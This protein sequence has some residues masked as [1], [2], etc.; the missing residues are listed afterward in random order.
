MAASPVNK[1][2]LIIPA[3]DNSLCDVLLAM[4]QAIAVFKA[5]LDYRVDPD[6]A[7]TENQPTRDFAN[8]LGALILPPGTVMPFSLSTGS[9]S[10]SELQAAVR[11]IWGA[12]E[13]VDGTPWWYLCDGSNGTP[14]LRGKFVRGS[15][16]SGSTVF[17]EGV[18]GGS[19]EVTLS[20]AN[21][22][23]HNHKLGMYTPGAGYAN[24]MVFPKI[25]EESV[26]TY[27]CRFLHTTSDGGSFGTTFNKVN[28]TTLGK[29]VEIAPVGDAEVDPIEMA[30]P[31]VNL[32]YAMRSTRMV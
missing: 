20:L 19:S 18:A 2:S 3:S 22:P 29:H 28:T 24:D 25:A 23:D 5:D 17:I 8:H 13:A 10:N 21:L 26:E 12:P 31:C 27:E 9:A 32:V 14:D 30:P 15:G 1:D 6:S 7:D 4:T 11:A 16:T